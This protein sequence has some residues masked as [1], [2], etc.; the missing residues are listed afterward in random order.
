MKIRRKRRK[1]IAPPQPERVAAMLESLLFVAEEPL[2]LGVLAR[3]LGV[4]RAA[5]GEAVD[6]LASE[7]AE[8][9]VRVQRSGELVQLVTA[10]E[11]APYVER[12]LEM[13]HH[14][15]STAALESLAI[16]AYRQ[17]V[18]RA[19]IN[20]I[21]GVDSDRVVATLMGRGLVEEVGRAQTIGRPA[22]LGTTVRFLEY[23][24]LEKPD[25][26]PP[27]SAGG[28]RVEEREEVLS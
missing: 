24:G 14:R 26:L 28:E 16:I 11:A 1:R 8:R 3:S 12:F 7:C 23:F 13:D 27:L 17:P 10:P 21:R 6:G 15:L 5:V 19:V 18:T 9:G 2:E 4:S 22:L 25:D 20:S